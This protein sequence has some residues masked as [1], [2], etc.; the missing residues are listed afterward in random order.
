MPPGLD[1]P[2]DAASAGATAIRGSALRSGGYIAGMFL[3]L[4]SGPLLVRHLGVAEFGV[5]VTITALV[6][7]VAG[8]SDLGLT[9]LGVREWAQRDAH[10]RESLMRDLLG[11]RLAFTAI[12][13]GGAMAFA[14]AAGYDSR[15]LLGT[16]LACVA[17][18]FM[19]LQ[20]ALTV[21]LAGQLRQGRIAAAD[22]VRQATQVGLIVLLVVVGA[23]LVP[24]LGAAIPAALAALAFTAA[25]ARGAIVMP[26]VHPRHWTGLLRGTIPFAAASAVSVVYLRTTIIIT[27]LVASAAENGQFAIAFRVIEVLVNVPQLLVGALFPLL[28]RMAV[29]DRAR[30]RDSLERTLTGSL[31]IGGL[32]ATVVATGAPIAVLAL[33]GSRPHGAVVALRILGAGLGFTFISAATLY[34]L[35][36]L[37][38]HRS[39]L[40]I[41]LGALAL[42]AALTL[43]LADAHGAIGAAIALAV[44][45]LAV[46]AVST[47]V[48]H[49]ALGGLR[50]GLSIPM[51]VLAAV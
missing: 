23:G 44:S 49:R 32:V 27:S 8:I 50:I 4:L 40:L 26:S 31:A 43:V 36:A 14:V 7:I 34:G 25:A 16:A 12:G 9:S 21:P 51:R 15:R 45:E 1:D 42:N 6:T 47:V 22:I 13:I 17:L 48:L 41:N 18:V 38:A 28:A 30:L 5:Y 37:R 2:L 46:A 3:A 39:I 35:L 33:S 24:L 10:E 20:G 19:A 11:A 29:T